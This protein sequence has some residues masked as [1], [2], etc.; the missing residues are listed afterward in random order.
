M[1]PHPE[2]GNMR[3]PDPEDIEDLYAKLEHVIIPRFEH[4]RAEWIKMMRS[5]I[6]INGSFFN[7][8]RM[9]EQYVLGAYFK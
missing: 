1:G 8:H 7:S 5:A 4:D 9:A 3:N 6:A 2:H